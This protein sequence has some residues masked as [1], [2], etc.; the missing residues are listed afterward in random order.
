MSEPWRVYYDA[1][2]IRL[3]HRRLLI[4]LPFIVFAVFMLWHEVSVMR[5][6][7]FSAT[8]LL[9]AVYVRGPM[10][11]RVETTPR[12]VLAVYPWQS[13]FIPWE[14]V[15]EVLL[16]GRTVDNVETVGASLLLDT[17]GGPAEIRAVAI[18]EIDDELCFMPVVT[19]EVVDGLNAGRF[20]FNRKYGLLD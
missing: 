12:G 5:I 10:R 11:V 13:R 8:V 4:G 18:R 1:A 3:A 9:L 20:T 15:S 17:R 14:H 19:V 6:I 2:A 7:I 16:L